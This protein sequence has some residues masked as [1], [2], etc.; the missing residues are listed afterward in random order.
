MFKYLA[1][2]LIAEILYFPL[3][4]YSRGVFR[5]LNII[6]EQSQDMIRA[7]GLKIWL[8]SIF[9]PM[10]GDYTKEG[11]IISF[12]MRIIILIFRLMAF[13]VWMIVLSILLLIW[14]SLPPAA[15]FM[16]IRSLKFGA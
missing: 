7:L 12:F 2:D 4:W 9:K 14:L 1:K 3:W 8:K 10:F 13:A 15:I 11:R 5:I 6:K 16:A